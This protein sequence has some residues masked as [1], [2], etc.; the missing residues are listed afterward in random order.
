MYREIPGIGLRNL[1]YK[2]Y[3]MK[4]SYIR[5][6]KSQKEKT[7]YIRSKAIDNTELI[8]KEQGEMVLRNVLQKIQKMRENNRGYGMLDS[9]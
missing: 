6:T 7:V 3:T 8:S 5:H 1:A 2:E 4:K 9:C